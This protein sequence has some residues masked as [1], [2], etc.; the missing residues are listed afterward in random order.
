MRPAISNLVK[1][2]YKDVEIIDHD[3]V[4]DFPFVRGISEN[5]YWIDHDHFQDGGNRKVHKNRYE[6][7]YMAKLTDYLLKQ[8]YT[9]DQ[10]T[11]L[12]AYKG[13][14]WLIKEEMQKV[15]KST[16]PR[17]V[18]VDDY[19]GEE[20]LIILLSLVR[21]NKGKYIGF[22]KMENRAIV[23]LSRAKHGLYVIGSSKTL[24]RDK[25]W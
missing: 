8:N 4:K 18:T 22:L 3:S 7:K 15:V 2:M 14:K 9:H 6:A 1:D 12:T 11:V 19:Q 13:Q 5:V 16:L 24:E 17:I 23:A 21:C 25:M 20:N 10:I